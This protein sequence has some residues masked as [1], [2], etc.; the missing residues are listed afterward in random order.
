MTI[1]LEEYRV[2][3]CVDG[4]LIPMKGPSEDEDTKFCQKIV[5]AINVQAICD[6]NSKFTN[7]IVKWAGSTHDAFMWNSNKIN[8]NF[9]EGLIR[10]GFLLGDSA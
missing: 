5:H 10:N 1:N 2:I 6:H 9:Q 3:G 4:S 8:A 7:V